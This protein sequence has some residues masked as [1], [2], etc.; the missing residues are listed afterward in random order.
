MPGPQALETTVLGGIRIALRRTAG[1]G[2][3]VVFVHGN[4]SSSFD[5][6]PFMERLR[7]PAIAFDLPGFG[8]SERPSADRFDFSMQAYAGWIG[9]AFDE[10]G[11]ERFGLL[12]HDW[13]A[14]ALQPASERPE[15][16]ERLAVIN[17]VPLFAGYRWHWVARLWRSRFGEASM[18]GNSKAA[19]A[20]ALRLARP[21]RRRCRRP[22]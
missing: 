20:A 19:F 17:A 21:G 3:P 12:V 2:D 16:V 9:T 22:G 13:G 5:W 18:R 1:E 14:I 6:V 11:L 7:R 10:L 4:P 15:R 8:A